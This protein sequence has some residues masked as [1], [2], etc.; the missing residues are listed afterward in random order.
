MKRSAPL[1]EEIKSFQDRFHVSYKQAKIMARY[2]IIY[3]VKI[4]QRNMADALR[5]L[6]DECS[7]PFSRIICF[8][9]GRFILEDESAATMLKILFG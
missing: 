4:K 3:E 1:P 8:Y 2:N 9:G 6:R 7:F 5:W